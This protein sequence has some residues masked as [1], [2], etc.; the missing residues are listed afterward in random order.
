MKKSS[1]T[2]RDFI[3]SSTLAG[4]SV[5]LGAKA[6]GNSSNIKPLSSLRKIGSLEVSPIGLGCM[7][8]AGVY[9][10]RM[11]K[12]AMIQVI[13]KAYENGVDFL[14]TAEV[15]GP[16]YS[17]EIVGEA[18]KPFRNKIN[19]ATKVGFSFNS[20]GGFAGKSSRP[21]SIRKAVDGCLQRLQTDVID[22]CYLH[23]ADGH[24]PAE[25]VAGAFKD[26]IKEGKIKNYGLSE[27]SPAFIKSA[28]SV[29]PVSALQSEYSILERVMEH[30]VLPLCEELG[31][32][33]VPWGP[34]T[35]GFLTGRFDKNT[36]YGF[37]RAQV[38]YLRKENLEANFKLLD[39]V[40]EKALEKN[41]TPA[42]WSL[43]WLLAQKPFIVPIPGTTN[44]N[45]LMENIGGLNLS[46][47]QNE[48]ADIRTS[49]EAIE[50]KGVRAPE[51][52]HTNL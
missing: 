46:F 44:E 3:A 11:P 8:M 49:I 16:F 21:D 14:D 4:V 23:R 25:D 48:L 28:H 40:K 26:L 29:H 45:H 1:I 22:L 13:R 51:S 9:N 30:E 35:R 12:E 37:R 24:T 27:V 6:L 15:Y 36:T 10:E 20:N 5:M 41:V 17:E 34:L 43:A 2:R 32:A 50:V 7:N 42:Q 47:T 19:L 52:V 33:F 38:P 39:F 18:I 31:I